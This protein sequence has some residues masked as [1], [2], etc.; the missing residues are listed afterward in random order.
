MKEKIYKVEGDN[1]MVSTDGGKK[2]TKEGKA[3]QAQKNSYNAHLAKK[4]SGK[5]SGQ[6]A[7]KP[8]SSV[9]YDVYNPEKIKVKE[10]RMRMRVSTRLF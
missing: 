2:Y 8:K 9:D 10:V 7:A 3:T 4:E 1:L 5:K 6:A